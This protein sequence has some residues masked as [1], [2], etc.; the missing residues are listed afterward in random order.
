[1]TLDDVWDAISSSPYLRSLG[2][3]V[4]PDESARAIELNHIPGVPDGTVLTA[5][6][7]TFERGLPEVSGLRFASYG[8]PAFDAILALTA[9]S[10]LPPGIRR[11]SVPI[12]GDRRCRTCR[13]CGDA[14]GQGRCR[15][16]LIWFST[17]RPGRSRHRRGDTVPPV[18]DREPHGAADSS[19]PE[20]SFDCWPPQRA[21]RRP[22]RGRDA[23][24]CG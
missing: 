14:A 10:G 5:S 13:L 23:H 20:M 22:T 2:C 4:L 15:R 3:R 17:W 6:R 21:S 8:E 19:A 12:P 11:I 24:N 9:A 7:D 18:R 1:M 16:R